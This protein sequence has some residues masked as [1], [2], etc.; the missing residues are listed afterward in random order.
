MF[1]DRNGH[2]RLI[3]IEQKADFRASMRFVQRPIVL[4]A[5]TVHFAVEAAIHPHRLALLVVFI[6]LERTRREA[7]TRH[8]VVHSIVFQA[9]F[10]LDHAAFQ[11][12]RAKRRVEFGAVGIA[13]DYEVAFGVDRDACR[14]NRRVQA[15]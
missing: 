14:R 11:S 12:R 8:F 6:R 7:E 3:H 10:D 9:P 2:S 1:V 5:L 4:S 15:N 13:V